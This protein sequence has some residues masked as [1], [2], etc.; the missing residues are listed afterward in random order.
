[1]MK[2][3]YR[4][5]AWTRASAAVFALAIAVAA[6]GPARAETVCDTGKAE[7]GRCD[8]GVAA[9]GTVAQDSAASTAEAH[10][11]PVEAIRRIIRDYLLEHPEVLIEAQQVLVAK[12]EAE[13]AE[14][15]RRAIQSHRAELISDPEAPVAG[16]PDGSITLV[17]FFDYRCGYCRRVKPTV[18]ALL[19]ENDDLRVVYKEFPILGPEST[20][21][22]HAA[23]ASRAQDGYGPFHAALMEAE[24]AFDRAQILAV[25]RSVG[26]DDERL[27]RDMEEPAIAALIQRNALLADALGIRGTPAFVIGDRLVGGALP[28]AE[29]RTIV[30]DARLALREDAGSPAD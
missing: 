13:E 29:F 22:A 23:L 3:I 7:D 16:N 12:R 28:L 27:A 1:M 8:P 2:T 15:E 19:A 25:A 11:L 14:Q 30:A 24:G 21:A 5:Y 18:E 10:D 6:T 9:A 26:L 4:S 20:L 17:E